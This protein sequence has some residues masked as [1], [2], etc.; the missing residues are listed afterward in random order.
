MATRVPR[1]TDERPSGCARTTATGGHTQ[2]GGDTPGRQHPY[3]RK[4]RLITLSR[5][6]SVRARMGQRRESPPGLLRETGLLRGNNPLGLL[7]VRVASTV[8]RLKPHLGSPPPWI[9]A[10]IN[11]ILA[12]HPIPQNQRVTGLS[13][14]L[15]RV[16]LIESSNSLPNSFP[17]KNPSGRNPPDGRNTS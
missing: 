4:T 10:V 13:P 7:R 1:L 6:P 9:A 5:Q 11:R 2:E 14:G 17:R 12:G 15:L 3:K 16:S 8:S